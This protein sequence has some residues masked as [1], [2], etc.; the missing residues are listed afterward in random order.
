VDFYQARPK[1]WAWS[2]SHQ[3]YTFDRPDEELTWP[4]QPHL[5]GHQHRHSLPPVP[6]CPTDGSSWK[7]FRFKGRS[8]KKA[9]IFKVMDT[10]IGH[11]SGMVEY[12][13]L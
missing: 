13:R 5:A 7:S 10:S 9:L 4:S 2:I 11:Q 8:L 3:V 1:G 6:A 12:I